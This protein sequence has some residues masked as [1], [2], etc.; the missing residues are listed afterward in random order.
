MEHCADELHTRWLIRVCF[1]K[2]HNEAERP[3]FEGRVCWAD[4]DCVP[5]DSVSAGLD[6]LY[7][8]YIRVTSSCGGRRRQWVS[9][10]GVSGQVVPGHDIVGNRRCRNTSGRVCLHALYRLLLARLR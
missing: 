7:A 5:T 10:A 6:I 2:V 3:V 4:D 8:F 9:R 1:L